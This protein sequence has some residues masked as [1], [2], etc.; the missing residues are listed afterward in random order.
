MQ[1]LELAL[2]ES[3]AKYVKKAEAMQNPC[4]YIELNRQFVE[5]NEKDIEMSET[6]AR[7]ELGLTSASSWPDLLREHRVVILSSAGTGKTS[8]ISHQCENLYQAGK[9]TFFLR[10]EDLANEWEVAFE[11]GDPESLKKAVRAGDEIWI[12]LDSIDEARLSDPRAFEKAL[13]RLKPHIKDNLQNVHIVLTSRIGAWRPKEDAA[14]LD[15]LFPYYPSVKSSSDKEE[16]VVPDINTLQVEGGNNSSIKYYTPLHLNR[17]QMQIFAN[18]RRL[19]DASAFVSEIQHPNMQGLVGR[20]KDL[21]DFILFWREHGRLGNRWEIVENNIKRKL[22][23]DDLDRAEKDSLSFKKA[24]AG[25]KKLAAAVALTH[26]SKV[27]VPD[28]SSPSEGISVQSVLADWSAKECFTL[29]GRPIFE[30]ETYGFVRFDHRDSREFLAA[31]WFFDLIERGQSRMRVEQLFFKTQYGIEV[32][33]PNLRPILPWLA[34][35]DHGIRRRVMVKWPEILLEGGDPSE[36]P[37]SDRKELLEQ[38]CTHRHAATE[39]RISVDLNAL[40]RLIT[41]ELGPAI[42]KL[43]VDYEGNEEIEILLLESIE[44]GLLQDLADIAERAVLKPFQRTYTRLAAMRALSAVCEDAKIASACDSIL[45]DNGLSSRQELANVLDVF[46]AKYIPVSSLMHLVEAVEPKE[47]YS[48]DR[49]N[50]AIVEYIN[51]CTINDVSHIVSESARLIKQAPLIERDFF[52]VS[53]KNAWMLDFATTACERLIKERH[54][55]AL[56][57]PCLSLLSL[58]NRSQ[59]YHIRETKTNLGELVLQWPELNAALFWYDVEDVRTLHNKKEGERLNNWWQVHVFRDLHRFDH[60]DIDQVVKWITQ[61]ESIDDRLVALTLAFSLYRDAGRPQSLRK[62]LW[63]VVK[64]N[65]ELSATLKRLLNPPA[66]SDEERRLKRS[67]AQWKRRGKERERKDAEYHN[68]WRIEIANWLEDIRENRVPPEGR[69][70][71]VQRYLFDRMRSLG[72]ERNRRAQPNWQDLEAEVGREAAE[73]MR[74]GLMANWRRYNPTLASEAGECDNSL[75][76]IESM[77]LSGLEIEFRETPDWPTSLDDVEAQSVARYLMSELNGFPIWFREF[78][79]QCP[80]ITLSVLLKEVVWELF[81]NPSDGPSHYLFARILW[82]APWFGDR[83]AP[84]LVPLLLEKEPRHIRVLGDA[85][86][87]I[88]GC[89]AIEN[90]QIAEL[91]ARK[92]AEATTPPAH[93][94]LWYAAWVS[95]DPLPAIDDLTTKLAALEDVEAVEFA[96]DFINALYG[97][98]HERGLGVHDGHK[99]PEHLRNLYVLMH[100]YIRREDDIDRTKGGVYTPTSRDYAQDARGYIYEN[101]ADIPGKDAFDA[102]ASI[103]REAPSGHARDWL[104]SRMDARA[105]ADADDPWTIDDVNE[106]ADELERTP[107]SPCKL[108]EVARNRLVDLKYKYEDGDTSPY[109][110][111]IKIDKE[112]ELRNY[113]A[114]RLK[115]TAHA[116]YS[117]SQEDEMPNAQRTDIRFVLAKIPGMVP[118]ELKIADKWS[119]PELFAKLKD[120]LCG[121]YLRDE[122]ST[123]GIYLLVHHGKKKLWQHPDSKQF[124]PFEEL[125]AALKRYAQD[126]IASSPGI[127]NIEVIGIDLIKRSKSM[128]K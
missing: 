100:Q 108:F 30:P 48:S 94:P 95:V 10:L 91:C 45:K 84:Y 105:Q 54:P 13:K 115:E 14:R 27:I 42:R 75:P 128:Q 116:R 22:T 90:D 85:L 69:S 40:Q 49:L 23:E 26:H 101:L 61:K 21:D 28:R 15:S 70:R 57:H 18:A 25:A 62:R 125:I 59:D 97:S 34:I 24:L 93:H 5:I 109:R 72:K 74:D 89:K 98:R 124:L 33:V 80:E 6:E 112:P 119:G 51:T 78:E 113:L 11:V 19:K 81:D 76:V 17:E 32:V 56:L 63:K 64:G 77:A 110:V 50:R 122:D 121:D 86:R 16:E 96:I 29:L 39:S 43:Y 118:V 55:A 60:K 120:Q 83:I 106:F 87:L 38:F 20:P 8:E 41:P 66:I 117:I 107:S 46:G 44:L 114:D 58:T 111:L 67:N 92:T 1:R 126:I 79:A 52:E 82:N 65:E 31:S 68:Q 12:F 47:R 53:K 4:N 9:P 103:A 36:L 35:Y 37:L 99:T 127:S 104:Y 73:A 2:A 102:L 3:V 71:N 123:N 88:M 7:I